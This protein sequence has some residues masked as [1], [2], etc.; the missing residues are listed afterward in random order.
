MT[1]EPNFQEG[2]G[3]MNHGKTVI[4]GGGVI[5]GAIAFELA[6]SGIKCELFE[7]KAFFSEAS[8]DTAGLLGGQSVRFF[9]GARRHAAIDFA[10]ESFKRHRDWTKKVELI[11]GIPVQYQKEGILRLAATEEEK[12]TIEQKLSET[13]LPVKWLSAREVHELEPNVSNHIIGGILFSEDAQLLPLALKSSLEQA[14]TKLGVVIHEHTEI[15]QLLKEE[16]QITGVQTAQ[17]EL[18]ETDTVILAAG[19]WSGQLL[20]KI[21]VFLPILP[22]RGQCYSVK[23]SEK[24]VNRTIQT[25]S[26]YMLP[27]LD[28]SITIGASH[29]QKDYDKSPTFGELRQLLNKATRLVPKLESAEFQR[30]WVGLRPGTADGYPVIGK[31]LGINGLF[32]ATGHYSTGVIMAPLTAQVVLENLTGNQP[33]FNLESFSPNR[34]FNYP[35]N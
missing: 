12:Q 24:L 33:S 8:I 18:I 5:G 2:L 23:P 3:A 27:R 32:V 25:D 35:K 30:T 34:R 11:S 9:D 31:L 26:V 15:S 7:K 6:L 28:G 21:G 16:D 19:A 4:I 10:W 13:T 17:G 20:E 1:P 14:L 29:L 22:V